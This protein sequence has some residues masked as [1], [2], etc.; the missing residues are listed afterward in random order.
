MEEAKPKQELLPRPYLLVG[1]LIIPLLHQGIKVHKLVVCHVLVRTLDVC[2]Q[3][4]G[5]LVGQLDARLENR[6]REHLG[7]HRGEPKPKLIMELHVLVRLEQLFQLWHPTRSKVAVLQAHPVAALTRRKDEGLGDGSLALAEGDHLE[8][9][10]N[11]RILGEVV[12]VHGGIGTGRQ[13]EDD[14]C[15]G[16]GVS[17][18]GREIKGWNVDEVLANVAHDK[19]C[20]GIDDLLIPQDP[21]DQELLE[22]RKAG[23]PGA[24]KGLILR[25]K[26][27]E[28]RLPRISLTAQ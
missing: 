4:L 17:K 28:P 27:V 14:G 11:A 10:E 24:R 5:R 21:H 25:S 22:W 9:L 8:A 18:G 12:E 23:L 2:P 1:T 3:A 16:R 13:Y 6:R 19:V 26:G 20:H 15:Q 7:G